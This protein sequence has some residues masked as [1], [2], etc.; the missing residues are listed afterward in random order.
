MCLNTPLGPGAAK[1]CHS[2]HRQ[3]RDKV[4]VREA[5]NVHNLLELFFLIERT[6]TGHAQFGACGPFS[7]YSSC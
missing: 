7:C 2:G 6:K 1:H 5:M 4:R 3:E